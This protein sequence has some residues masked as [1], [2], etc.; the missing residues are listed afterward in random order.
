M[1]ARRLRAAFALGVALCFFAALPLAGQAS[2]PGYTQ[3]VIL[4]SSNGYT[5]TVEAG[6]TISQLGIGFP[7]TSIPG[8]GLLPDQVSYSRAGRPMLPTFRS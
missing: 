2:P 6:A 3:F 1:T 8:E 5:D 7:S 4:D